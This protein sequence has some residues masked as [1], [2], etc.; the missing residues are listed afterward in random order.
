MKVSDYIIDFIASLG[1]KNI[2]CVT[3]G[4]A[5]HMNNSDPAITTIIKPT[6]NTAPNTNF[7]N[8]TGAPAANIPALAIS[9]SNPPN[10]I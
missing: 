4:G 8:P 1:V 10:A 3:G 5:M 6:G 9:A 7:S 2:F